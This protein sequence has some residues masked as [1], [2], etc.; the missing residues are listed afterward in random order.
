M[1]RQPTPRLADRTPRVN[2]EPLLMDS[3]GFRLKIAFVVK[4]I[5]EALD[6]YCFRM[7]DFL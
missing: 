4:T 7:V 3:D 2:P 6:I 5:S 1:A